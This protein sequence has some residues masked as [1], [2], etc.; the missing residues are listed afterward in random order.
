MATHDLSTINQT[1]LQRLPVAKLAP[2]Y[3]LQH[4]PGNGCFLN[5]PGYPTYFTRAVYDSRGDTPRHGP[6]MVLLDR[7]VTDEDNYP[8]DE[9]HQAL[10][11]A[12]WAPLPL[13]HKRT[14]AWILSLYQHLRHCYIDDQQIA[15]NRDIRTAAA[16]VAIP[17]NHQAVRII[18]KYYPLYNPDTHLI[19]DPILVLPNGREVRLGDW[20]ERYAEQPTPTE[21]CPPSWLGPHR[22]EGWCQ[23]C[24]SVDNEMMPAY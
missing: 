12:L 15:V 22:T 19:E 18:R 23:F 20:W 21:C 6:S 7:V 1:A 14:Q 11:R 3:H 9:A 13:E 10:L 16:K 24:G 5:P 2:T 8:T 4:D 17:E